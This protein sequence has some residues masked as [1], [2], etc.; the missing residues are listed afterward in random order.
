MSILRHCQRQFQFTERMSACVK[1]NM[2]TAEQYAEY[3]RWISTVA[4]DIG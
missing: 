4:F 3:R 2:H 1:Y